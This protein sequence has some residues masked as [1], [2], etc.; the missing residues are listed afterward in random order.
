ELA[1]RC[2]S[3][4][5]PSSARQRGHGAEELRSAP[6]APVVVAIQGEPRCT[7]IGPIG[8]IGGAGPQLE[9]PSVAGVELDRRVI[10]GEDE[11]GR[12]AGSEVAVAP[13]RIAVALV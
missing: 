4:P 11:G 6:D 2:E 1:E 7:R 3:V 9:P 12:L 8:L 5:R 13:V 10:K